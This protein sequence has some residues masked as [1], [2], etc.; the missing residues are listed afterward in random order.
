MAS[1]TKLELIN[2]AFDNMGLASYVFDISSDSQQAALRMLSSM[3]GTWAAQGINLGYPLYLDPTNDDINQDSNLPATAIEATY[4]N[5]AIRM[6]PS[7]G[8]TVSPEAKETARSAFNAMLTNIAPAIP[9]LADKT[10]LGAGNRNGWW[11]KVFTNNVQD[12]SN[13]QGIGFE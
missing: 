6:S 12:A 10:I 8:K 4:L 7:Y 13:V 5:L 1:Y 2:A 11:G 9:V 3:M